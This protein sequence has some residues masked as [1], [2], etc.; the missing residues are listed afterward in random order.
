[1]EHFNG[2]DWHCG[3]IPG[4][5]VSSTVS[6]DAPRHADNVRHYG[7]YLIAESVSPS[8][9]TILALSKELYFALKEL[10]DSPMCSGARNNAHNLLKKI[11]GQ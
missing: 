7:G 3:R 10:G 4:T 11:D 2:G 6:G 1:M 9:L 5:I 8:N